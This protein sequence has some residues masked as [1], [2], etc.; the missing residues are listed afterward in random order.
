L[1]KI[2]NMD[3][4]KIIDIANNAEHKSNKD[5]ELCLDNLTIEFKKT[6]EVILNLTNHLDGIMEL[7]DKV[8]NEIGKRIIK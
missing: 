4:D 5:L 7:Y 6:K 1:E 2:G 3:K 8:N